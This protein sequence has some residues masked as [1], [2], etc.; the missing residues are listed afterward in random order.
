VRSVT[1]PLVPPGTMYGA[2]LNQVDLRVAKDFK[3][4]E[5]VSVQGYVDVY[6]LLNG[7]TTLAQNNTFGPLWQNPT[8]FLGARQGKFGVLFKF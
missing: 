2:R 3:V 1:V 4:K 7:N 5:G 8:A 6:N